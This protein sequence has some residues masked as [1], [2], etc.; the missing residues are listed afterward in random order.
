M[1]HPP[2][3]KLDCCWPGQAWSKLNSVCV[4]TP[5]CPPNFETRGDTCID[6]EA[7]REAQRRA[8]ELEKQREAERIRMEGVR[9]E[10]E[11]EQRRQAEIRADQERQAAAKRAEL[12]KIS[13]E[14]KRVVDVGDVPSPTHPHRRLSPGFAAFGGARCYFFG[15]GETHC[16]PLVRLD[17]DFSIGTAHASV[18]YGDLFPGTVVAGFGADIGTRFIHLGGGSSPA[19]MAV[20]GQLDLNFASQSGLFLVEQIGL[21]LPFSFAVSRLVSIDLSLSG[22]VALRVTNQQT[23]TTLNVHN[24]TPGAFFQPMLGVRL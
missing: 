19:A 6:L 15:S 16:G 11:A 10:Q 17:L 4:G 3:A 21:A 5:R 7:E 12:D 18:G 22:G 1:V 8:A 14:K 24:L 2:N 13:A 23:A 9:R 20:R